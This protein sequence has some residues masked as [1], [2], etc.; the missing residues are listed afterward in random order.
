MLP[1]RPVFPFGTAILLKQSPLYH[2]LRYIN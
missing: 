1:V 2:P